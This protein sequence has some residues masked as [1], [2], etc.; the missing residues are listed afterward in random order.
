MAQRWLQHSAA[1]R[2]GRH[3]NRKVQAAYDQHGVFGF[4]VICYC[5]VDDLIAAEQRCLDSLQPALNISPR[6]DALVQHSDEA[7]EKI[8][9][10]QRG[11]RLPQ[12]W[13]DAIR[14]AKLQQS[15]ETIA[16]IKASNRGQKRSAETRAR[17]R[18]ARAKQVMTPE[19]NA[20][21]SAALRG[22]PKNHGDKISKTKRAQAQT[23]DWRAGHQR[24][25]A[26]S[27]EKRRGKPLSDEHR[28][29]IAESMRL[30]R[31]KR[32]NEQKGNFLSSCGRD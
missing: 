14:A 24:A 20:K 2:R 32:R 13:R 22:V 3:S 16:K 11:R 21:R 18:A 30:S 31:E 27:A 10:A 25:V 4:S 19:S 15:A 6:A 23:A 26:A 12:E 7:K 17:V 8:A 9:A 1:A 29:K 5:P 28:A